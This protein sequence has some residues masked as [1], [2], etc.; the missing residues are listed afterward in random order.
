MSR[1][2]CKISFKI[3]KANLHDFWLTADEA[4]K[5]LCRNES[6]EI[7]MWI[8]FLNYNLHALR[9]K[10]AMQSKTL[11]HWN[12]FSV[13]HKWNFRL[14]FWIFKMPV[15]NFPGEFCLAKTDFCFEIFTLQNSQLQTEFNFWAQSSN[16]SWVHLAQKLRLKKL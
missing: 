8:K 4:V 10:S 14:V 16:I 9:L 6:L 13:S 15:Q 7:I 5:W 12:R 2:V 1:L 3:F 11:A